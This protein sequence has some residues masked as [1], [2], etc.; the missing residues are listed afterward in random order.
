MDRYEPHRVRLTFVPLG[1]SVFL[2]AQDNEPTWH[3]P[4]SQDTQG[5]GH[6]PAG[7]GER[8]LSGP[9]LLCP[10]LHDSLSWMW[11]PQE[12]TG[13]SLK[14]DVCSQGHFL[15]ETQHATVW[16]KDASKY[17]GQPNSHTSL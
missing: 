9:G 6:L 14:K 3:P 10:E 15:I 11:D 7:S 1:D 16:N 13:R 2:G 4:L 17:L 8:L 12:R 5:G